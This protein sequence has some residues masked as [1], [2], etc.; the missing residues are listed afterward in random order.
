ERTMKLPAIAAACGFSSANHLARV[1]NRTVG[2]SPQAV[3]R[4]H[5]A[6]GG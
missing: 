4:S 5:L 1:F 3:R 6:N 2:R